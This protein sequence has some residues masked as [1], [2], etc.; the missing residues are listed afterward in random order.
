[1]KLIRQ[2]MIYS[3]RG[4]PCKIYQ[5]KSR[6]SVLKFKKR[7]SGELIVKDPNIIIN[8]FNDFFT[9]IGIEL[10]Q[11]HGETDFNTIA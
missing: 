6:L 5:P 3:K 2:L 4:K 8:N 7:V 9:N 1:M 10:A 11:T